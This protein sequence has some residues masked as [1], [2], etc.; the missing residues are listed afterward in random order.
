MGKTK[1]TLFCWVLGGEGLL[2]LWKTFGE[3]KMLAIATA[4]S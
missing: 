1:L 4:K 3:K 2:R